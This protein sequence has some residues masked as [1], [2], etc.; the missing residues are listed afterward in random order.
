MNEEKLTQLKTMFQ[1]INNGVGKAEFVASFKALMEVVLRREKAIN[2]FLSKMEVELKEK[3]ADNVQALLKMFDGLKMKEESEMSSMMSKHEKEMK[4]MMKDQED[5][6][7]FIRDKVR[8]IKEGADGHTPTKDE[9]ITLITPLIPL[10]IPPKEETAI[11]TRD[12]LEYI[13]EEKEKL[14]IEAIE[15]L[16][17]EIDELKARPISTG[18]GGV[19]DMRIRQAFKYIFHTEEPTG[20]IDGANLTY[21]VSTPI[22]AI[23]GFTLNGESIAELPNYTFANRTITFASALPAAYSGKDFECKFIG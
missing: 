8:K 14:K 11:E 1:T 5:S 7:N 3:G 18:G 22:W 16:R 19:T 20:A 6:L 17:K 21:T 23:I 12:K 13:K 2:A 15:N 9:L 10:P 4:K